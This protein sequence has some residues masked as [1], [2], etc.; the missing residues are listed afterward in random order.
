MFLSKQALQVHRFASSDD[1]RYSLTSVRIEADGSTVAT[2]SHKLAKYTPHPYSGPK[3]DEHTL[4]SAN[5]E[6]LVPFLLP[7]NDCKTILKN[8]PKGRTVSGLRAL[9]YAVVDTG[10]TNESDK[11]RIVWT[12]L[13]TRGGISPVKAEGTFP[14]YE[15]VI[16]EKSDMADPVGINPKYLKQAAELLISQGFTTCAISF[17]RENA[18]DRPVRIDAKNEDGSAVIIIMPMQ[19]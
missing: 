4:S 13:E 18:P 6:P 8:L 14:K 16:P 9:G 2:D 12:D 3:L 5:E 15:N 11:A 17:N 1:T 10:V 19:L 7:V